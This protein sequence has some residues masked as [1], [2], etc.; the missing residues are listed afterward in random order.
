MNIA[1]IVFILSGEQ[2]W[3]RYDC[4]GAVH[5]NLWFYSLHMKNE[6]VSNDVVQMFQ[7]KPSLKAG[8][9]TSYEINSY[10]IQLISAP[11]LISTT[12]HPNT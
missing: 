9:Q 12:V 5:A 8:K 1:R 10:H 4:T 11:G 3:H 6:Q 2:K 7:V